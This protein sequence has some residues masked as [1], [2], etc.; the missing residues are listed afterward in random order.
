MRGALKESLK[1]WPLSFPYLRPHRPKVGLS[2]VLMALGSGVALLEPWPLALLVDSVLGDKPM[3]GPLELLS[4]NVATRVGVVMALMLGVTLAASGLGVLTDFV[5]TKIEMKMV[6]DFR[7]DLFR[8]VQ[9]LSFDY[10]DDRRTGEFMGRINGQASSVGAVTVAAFPLFGSLLTLIGM[11][12]VAYRLNPPVALLSLSV[13]PLIYYTTGYYGSRIGPEVRK[14]K[15]MEIRSLHIVHEAVQM[16]RVIVAFNREKEEYEK[17][18]KQGEEAVD[19]R[20]KVTVKQ[21]VFN[22][23]VGLITAAGIAAVLGVGA[24][25]VRQGNLT[26]GQLL[27]LLAYIRAVYTPLETISATMNTIQEQLIGFEMALELLDTQ[28]DVVEKPDAIAIEQV[29]GAVSFEDVAFNYEGREHT[30]RDITFDVEPGTSVAIV[31]P[32]GAGKTTLVSLLPRFYDP[33]SG[34]ILV[35]GVDIRDLTL[36]SLRG[37]I[38]LVL[39]EPLL[40]SGTIEDNIR[41]GRPEAT[42]EEIV[43]AAKAANAHDFIKELPRNYR[44]KLGER[45]AKLSGGERQRLSVARAFLKDAPILVLDEPTSSIDSRTEAVILEALGRLME[46]RTTFMVAHRLSTIQNARQI[47]VIDQ[48][49]LLESGTHSEL[50][51][52]N[53]LYRLLHDAQAGRDVGFF[54]PALEAVASGIA[55]VAVTGSDEGTDAEAMQENPT[56]IDSTVAALR[57]LD[58]TSPA[59][60]QQQPEPEPATSVREFLGTSNGQFDHATASPNGNGHG[61][62]GHP[63]L[64]VGDF[65]QRLDLERVGPAITKAVTTLRAQTENSKT[66]KDLARLAV[67][68]RGRLARLAEQVTGR[69]GSDK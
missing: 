68:G 30:L 56:S 33:T 21:T 66:G 2:M 16:I 26:T 43:A 19:A 25:Q 60:E 67:L 5:N 36:S 34:R 64:R 58:A 14:V 23:V 44:T 32:T 29:Q 3:P 41:Y 20:I 4:D 65:G 7:S 9:R 42:K 55:E 59:E 24:Y 17:F 15:G 61:H 28:P 40:F 18:R 11:F 38:S 53:G 13:V 69:S 10:H 62:N 35:D 45:G 39:Q 49:C 57:A 6:L 46:G 22:G 50:L 12:V 1:S 63:K 48:G 47:L 8:H 51:E 27:V 37:Q 52:Q 31:G 54:T